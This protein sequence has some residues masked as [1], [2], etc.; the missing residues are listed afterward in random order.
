MWKGAGLAGCSNNLSWPQD[1]GSLQEGAGPRLRQAMHKLAGLAATKPWFNP[2]RWPLLLYIPVGGFWAG[3]SSRQPPAGMVGRIHACGL[4]L[5][6]ISTGVQA[7]DASDW[8]EAQVRPVL[9]TH[10]WGCHGPGQQQSG[11]R[12]DSRESIL[13]GGERGPAIVPGNQAASLLLRALRHEGPSMPPTGRLSATEVSAIATWVEGGAAWPE[14]AG[15]PPP[16]AS[17]RGAGTHWAFQPVRKIEPPVVRNESWPR[18]DIDQFILSRLEERGWTPSRQADRRALIR[19]VSFDLTGLPPRP[20]AVEGFAQSTSPTVYEDLVDRLLATDQFGEHWARHW[21][22]WVRYCESHGSQGDFE[23]PMAW[24]YRDYVIR[25]FNADVPYDRM[26]REYFAGDLLKDPRVNAETGLNESMLGPGNLRMVEYGYVPVDALED[27]LKVVENQIDVFSKAFQGLTVACA[28]CHDHK[29][30]PITQDDF[31]ALYGVFASSRPGL[32]TVDSAEHLDAGRERLESLRQ[33]IR[34]QIAR[35]WKGNET[36]ALLRQA[37]ERL[38]MGEESGSEGDPEWQEGTRV[39]KLLDNLRRLEPGAEHPLRL[40]LDL[41]NLDGQGFRAAWESELDRWLKAAQERRELRGAVYRP[42]WDLRPGGDYRD[43]YPS[44]P[45]LPPRAFGNGEIH[46]LPEGQRILAGLLPAGLYTGLDS[47]KYGGILGSPRF[48]IESDYISLKVTG[49]SFP[50]AK[51]IVENYPIGNGGIHPATDIESDAPHWIR[52]DTSYRKGQNAHLELQTLQDRS[53]PFRPRSK[54]PERMPAGGGRSSFG[55]IEVVFHDTKEPVQ[56]EPLAMLHLLEGDSGP[57]WPEALETRIQGLVRNAAS[58]WEE[59]RLDAGQ[60][61]FLDA[62]VRAGALPVTLEEMPDVRGLVEEYREHEA[63]A[64]QPRRAPGVLPGTSFDQALFLRGDH[65]R[66]GEPVAR[67]YLGFLGGQPFNASGSG[68]LALADAVASPRNPL[69]ARVLVNRLWHYLFGRGLVETV[70]NF[71]TA[72]EPPSHPELLDFLADR[73]V[74]EG[75]SIKGLVRYMVLSRTYQ[76][77]TVASAA[78]IA[79][80]PE[81]RLLQHQAI[82]RLPAESIRDAI[83]ETSGDLDRTMFGPSINVYYVGKTEGGGTPGPL[84]GSRRRSIYQAVRRNA[85]NPFLKVFDAPEPATTRGRRDATNIPVQ[86]LAMLNDPFVVNQS[87]RWA[88]R[89][90]AD[91]SVSP[92]DR[93][94]R[95]FRRATGRPPDGR[96]SDLLMSSLE[97][98]ARE[99]GVPRSEWMGDLNL[100]KDLAQTLFNLKEFLYLR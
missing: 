20:E 69:T 13:K 9:A 54:D 76:M 67:R 41:R 1:P 85:Q 46:V 73:F 38:D 98:L 89:A 58:A 71:G 21:M 92:T 8:F 55:V 25:A 86:S 81:N 4:G 83:L 77:G 97:S 79:G 96:E 84:D 91:G 56:D 68:R 33:R 74:A 7:S 11:L 87:E 43:W 16:S 36:A 90:L 2:C 26:I 61:A 82:R 10:C 66:P 93:M 14:A 17:A 40:W 42:A 59:R 48:R 95:M 65:T 12:L 22:D 78:A 28:R 57:R 15:A 70:D 72:G 32:V 23:L 88:N 30:D 60:T 37:A 63:K 99:R 39:A 27:Q 50:S 5:L 64:P 31:F 18:N 62:M 29:F 19:R 35:A 49:T 52:F 34:S 94:A 47:P 6:I 51:V 100:W 80:D 24:R 44:G 3:V 75:W 53:R 45:G